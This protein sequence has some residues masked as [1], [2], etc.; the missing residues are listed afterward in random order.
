M[1]WIWL[2][3]FKINDSNHLIVAH[4][5]L[6]HQVGLKNFGYTVEQDFINWTHY[7]GQFLWSR[8]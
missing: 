2:V 6:F 3:A 5:L 4:F 1:L 7:V 8:F